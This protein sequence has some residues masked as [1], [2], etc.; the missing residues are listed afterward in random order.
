MTVVTDKQRTEVSRTTG[1]HPSGRV[2]LCA[3]SGGRSE[4]VKDWGIPPWGCVAAT[5]EFTDIAPTAVRDRVRARVTVSGWLTEADETSDG[6]RCLEFSHAVLETE[7]RKVT[8]G[9]G[10]LMEAQE[11]PL[12]TCE[13]S[14]LTHL[15]DD[16][17]DM[18]GVLLRLVDPRH[19]RGT[20]RAVP[21]AIDRYGITLR[22]EGARRHNDVRLPFPSPIDHAD[23]A[24]TRIREL[25]AR[26]HQRT[27]RNR[28]Q[29]FS[30]P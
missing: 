1:S 27:Y 19:L 18:V 24:G 9:L 23:Q 30:N 16:H 3:S 7:D 14:M 17:G 28:N 26:A 22:L 20:V 8:I 10:E 11:D 5:L 2:H 21:L 25:L 12:A 13:A 4:P 29:S 6:D 15:I